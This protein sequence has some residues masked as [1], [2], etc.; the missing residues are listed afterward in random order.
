MAPALFTQLTG[1][2]LGSI[3]G[4]YQLQCE[5][6]LISTDQKSEG[7]LVHQTNEINDDQVQL[8]ATCKM[9]KLALNTANDSA[10]DGTCDPLI[11]RIV[12]NIEK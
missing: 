6:T 7:T 3:M 10:K 5:E 12:E 2:I 11:E 4:Q 8:C 1:D 9:K